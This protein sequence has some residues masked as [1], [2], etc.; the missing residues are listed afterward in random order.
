MRTIK[1]ILMV[2]VMGLA[3][4]TGFA[5]FTESS[6]SPANNDNI[7]ATVDATCSIGTFDLD[8]GV[9][10]PFSGAVVDETATVE[11]HCTKGIQPGVT[12]DDGDNTGRQMKHTTGT[13]LLDYELYSD[14]AGGTVWPSAGD[15]VFTALASTDPNVAMTL[16]IYGRIAA[17]QN[18]EAGDYV[19]TVVATVNW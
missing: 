16:T 12:L 5:Q 10:D 17:N 2:V 7:K 13:D 18:V 4:T 6:N 3:A 1:T 11:I 9:Y 15:G 19:D 14:S 8:F